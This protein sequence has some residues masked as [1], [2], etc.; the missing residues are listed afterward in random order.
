M[1]LKAMGMGWFAVLALAMTTACAP[2][3]SEEGAVAE[4][5]AAAPV[6]TPEGFGPLRIGMTLAEVTAAL[7]PDSEPNAVGGADPESC[8]QFRPARAPE[9]VLVMMEAGR[10]T[11]IS[12]IRQAAVKTDRGV[13][14]GSSAAEVKAAYRGAAV[15]SPHKYR[16]APSEYLTFWSRKAVA[17][18]RSTP[19][20]RGMVYEVDERGTV[21][22][23]HAGGPSIQYVEGCS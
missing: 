23:I 6:L 2:P 13:G 11:R 4:K 7:G 21:D 15:S 18:D 3:R 8:D 12:L 9:G 16:N 14:L 10:L 22:L 1:R 17:G 5:R 20:D 19:S